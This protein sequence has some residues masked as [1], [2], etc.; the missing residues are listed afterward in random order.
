MASPAR[1]EVTPDGLQ[2]YDE[3]GPRLG[4]ARAMTAGEN[5]RATR[6]W[7]LYDW[8]NSAFAIICMTAVLPPYLAGLA[9]RELGAPAGTAVW[10]WTAAAGLLAGA[11][12]APFLGAW[13]DATGRRRALLAAFAALGALGTVGIAAVLPGSWRLAA[14]FYVIAATGFMTANLFYDSLLPAVGPVERWDAIS[15]RGYAYGHAGGGLVLA[16]AAA[17][18]L[19][20]GPGMVR[21][22]LVLVAVW[23]A[24]FTVPVVRRVAEPAAAPGERALARLRRT[25]AE[26][27]SRPALWRFLL[28]Y[29]IYN[30]GIGTVIKMAGAYGAELGIPLA[31]MLGALL[32][33]QLVGI[34]ATL[35]FAR[36]ARRVG[37]KAG[38]EIALAGYVAIAAVGIFMAR[39]WHFWMLAGLVGLVQGGAQALS[40][41]LYARLLPAGRE[42][43]YF[44]F[45]DV[46]GR[47][48]GVAGPALF[49]LLTS[50]SG[51]GRLGVGSVLI[52]FIAGA[53][54]LRSVDLS[55]ESH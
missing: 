33:A 38:I 4:Q 20:R 34:P 3:G 1:G 13:A 25:L 31:H 2:E 11:L 14:L 55:G 36:L 15:A 52:F 9:N 49:A 21:W 7:C 19:A 44:S 22:V 35:A 51:S 40:R 50:L 27:R 10:G 46:S 29:W 48:A 54:L 12:A 23:W 32:L 8:G 47:M 6:A 26:A 37:T 42:A 17:L 41:S 53:L 39:P 5:A 30:D 18:V 43:E 45:F 28:A 24:V 16:I